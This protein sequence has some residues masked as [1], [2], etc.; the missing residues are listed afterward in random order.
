MKQRKCLPIPGTSVPRII[1][2]AVLVKEANMQTRGLLYEELGQIRHELTMMAAR[3]EENFCKSLALIKSGD[4]EL[5]KEIKESSKLVDALQLKIEDMALAIIATQQPKARDLRELITVFKLTS[6]IERIDDYG[7][8]LAKAAVKLASRPPFRSYKRIE[9][10]AQTGLEMFRQAFAAYLA[11]DAA[12]ARKAS[13][14]DDTID[15]EHKALMEELLA[16]MKEKPGL[17]KAASRLLRL[18]GYMERLGDHATNICEG[19][20]FMIEGRHEELN[21]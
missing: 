5:A 9:T 13:A 1:F 6:N 2:Q 20:T 15:E 17:V 10:M 7:V 8:H 4:K 14:L 12:A 16:L 18:S 3:T 19:I 11:Q 21:R